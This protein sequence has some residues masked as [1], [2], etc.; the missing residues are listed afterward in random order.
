METIIIANNGNNC[1][2]ALCKCL[3]VECKR[4]HAPTQLSHP[5][6]TFTCLGCAAHLSCQLE[7][8]LLVVAMLTYQTFDK[9]IKYNGFYSILYIFSSTT[10][11]FFF[12]EFFLLIFPQ[13]IIFSL[14]LLKL[15][16][17]AGVVMLREDLTL[18]I[19]LFGTLVPFVRSQINFTQT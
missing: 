13:N 1:N 5:L 14:C 3:N 6:T 16:Q 19:A 10:S 9:S 7:G 15:L 4:A 17:S 18:L 2:K 8:Y 11:S 12:C